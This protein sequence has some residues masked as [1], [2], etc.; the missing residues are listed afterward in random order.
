VLIK[1]PANGEINTKFGVYRTLCCGEEIVIK[2]GLFFPDCPN[3]P[4][5][6]TV[7][8]PVPDGSVRHVSDLVPKNKNDDSAA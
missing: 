7:W 4:R 2:E 6:S 5:L 8:K 3:H 1:M